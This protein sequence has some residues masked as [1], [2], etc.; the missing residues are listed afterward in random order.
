MLAALATWARAASLCLAQPQLRRLELS[1]LGFNLADM[2]VTIG[3]GVYAFDIGGVTAVGLITLARTLP[4]MVS[5]P[6]FSVVTD[7]LSRRTVLAI[8][9]WG[10][11]LVTG[12]MA[13]ALAVDSPLWAL[14]LLAPIDVILASSVYPASAALIPDLSRKAEELGSANAVFSLMENAGSLVGPLVAAALIAATGIGSVFAVSAAFYAFGA[15]A[16]RSLTS[17]RTIGTLR[18]IRFLTEL[19]EG[20][21]TLRGHWDARTVV[22]V[23][24][25]ESMLVGVLEVAVVVVALDLL[26]W[27]DAGVGLLAALIGIGGVLGA[28][29]L[30][31]STR[32]RA[33][34]RAMT[35]ALALFGVGLAGASVPVVVVVA[36]AMAVVGY[37]MSQ[38]DVAGQTLLQRT[39]PG[40]SLGRVLG[41]AEGLYW[42]S[43]G[44]G[45]LI[46]S[47]VIDWLGPVNAL[48]VF[49]DRHPRRHASPAADRRRGRR[50]PGSGPRVR[51]VRPV[52]GPAHPHGRIPGCPCHREVLPP[53]RNGHVR[54]GGRGRG[55]CHRL[56]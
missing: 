3:L 16:A 48:L 39:T 7:R 13:L 1:W 14:Y 4:A 49:A 19:K 5:G 32:A 24:A 47:L 8:G 20:L 22:I 17:D 11:A 36:L 27:D 25:L 37:S 45:A 2:A 50:G 10:R 51:S 38:A 6:L 28:A 30:A 42:A 46:A 43:V 21:V 56:W 44:I 9:F 54:R 12:L 35:M 15:L 18:G 41:L 29:L 53:G 55:L 40:D 33:Y 31:S 34:G 23:W 26:D 52:R